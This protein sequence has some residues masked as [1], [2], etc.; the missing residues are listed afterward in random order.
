MKWTHSLSRPL[1]RAQAGYVGLLL[2][3]RVY[4]LP[5]LLVVFLARGG[6]ANSSY[7]LDRS[8]LMDFTPSSQRGRWNAVESLTSMTWSGSAFFGGFLADSHNYRYTF[9]I[10]ALVYGV[11][12]V[13]YSPLLVLV[14][15]KE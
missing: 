10:T 7:P 3:A 15:R 14:P 8:I 6:F 9:L 5:I 12:Q 4:S 11:A 2:L 1:G 13:C